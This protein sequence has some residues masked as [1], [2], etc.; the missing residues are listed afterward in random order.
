[1]ITQIPVV[2]VGAI[3]VIISVL[4]WYFAGLYSSGAPRVEP[5]VGFHHAQMG[6][7]ALCG[8]MTL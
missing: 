8:Q 1:M 3:A 5:V 6:R 4:C 7:H 2:A